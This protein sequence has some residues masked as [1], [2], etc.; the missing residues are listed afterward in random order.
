MSSAIF[1]KSA[2]SIWKNIPGWGFGV[3]IAAWTYDCFV[4]TSSGSGPVSGT[5]FILVA[6][7]LGAFSISSRHERK[8]LNAAY[9]TFLIGL[10]GYL[11]VS[12]APMALGRGAIGL[13]VGC[14][15]LFL[16][17]V[18]SMLSFPVLLAKPPHTGPQWDLSVHIYRACF[19]AILVGLA[20]GVALPYTVFES[21]SAGAALRV[22]WGAYGYALFFVA[23]FSG[24]L[25]ILLVFPEKSLSRPRLEG[26]RKYLPFLVLAFLL[27]GAFEQYLRGHG[28]T[29]FLLSLIAFM[30]TCAASYRALQR[31]KSVEVSVE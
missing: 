23:V 24:T 28:W 13:A 25:G 19:A 31:I 22:G 2:R 18:F 21:R 3:L 17:L 16:A 1:S 6:A 15:V 7:L 14:C 20:I 8:L 27:W 30:G 4:H 26:P 9:Q 10:L 29:L 11:D 12:R 5:A